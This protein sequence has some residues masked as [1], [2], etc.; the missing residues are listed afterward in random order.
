MAVGLSSAKPYRRRLLL[1]LLRCTRTSELPSKCAHRRP[2]SSAVADAEPTYFR[3]IFRPA[4]PERFT[5]GI[6]KAFWGL[7]RLSTSVDPIAG[8]D[9]NL[10]R[11][12]IQNM[13]VKPIV[14]DGVDAVAEENEARGEKDAVVA[15][16]K[17][18][19]EELCSDKV[20]NLEELE[21]LEVRQEKEES[22]VE[23]EA[24]RLLNRAVVSYCGRP[25]GTV[26]ANDAA[27]ANQALNYD[28][29]FIR[30]FVPSAIAF[31]LKG[32]SE[33]VRNFL[34]HTLQLQV[35]ITTINL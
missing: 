33:I 10:E 21:A 9:K 6:P 11:I 5:P 31:L 2:F 27:T 32:E 19:K 15:D 35:K 34:L 12:F 29:V 24:W 13:A 28:Q 8:G 4:D 16:G 7:R 23:K 25:I 20:G 22:E 26:A 18:Q 30:D 3:R 14:I 1:V 17:E